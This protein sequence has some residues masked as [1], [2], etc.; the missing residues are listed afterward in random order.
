M[1]GN[2]SQRFFAKYYGE[3]Q[4]T[5]DE[6]RSQRFFAKYYEAPETP[7]PAVAEP[8]APSLAQARPAP[9]PIRTA[10]PTPEFATALGVRA[11]NASGSLVAPSI[12]TSELDTPAP[13]RAAPPPTSAPVPRRDPFAVRPDATAAVPR[14]P[15][16]PGES[17]GDAIAA[18]LRGTLTGITADLTL[19]TGR[20]LARTMQ[21]PAA[22]ETMRQRQ[23]EVAAAL[24]PDAPEGSRAARIF[25]GAR[26][27]TS[28]P[29]E[30]AKYIA[31]GG[32]VRS[33]AL[34]II[35][36]VG[37]DSD[38][39][40]A[41]MLAKASEV[42][43]AENAQRLFEAASKS[44]VG[45]GLVSAATNIPFE[46]PT[47]VRGFR[48][49]RA[50]AEQKRLSDLRSLLDEVPEQPRGRDVPP[51]APPVAPATDAGL[52]P[53]EVPAVDASK[54]PAP[55]TEAAQK[56]YDEIVARL[57]DSLDAAR[58]DGNDDDVK[59]IELLIRKL[60]ERSAGA[61][62]KTQVKAAW[63]AVGAELRAAERAEAVSTGKIFLNDHTD[64][65]GKE[66]DGQ[67]VRPAP[68]IPARLQP[69]R[70]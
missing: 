21:N 22:A 35:E 38:E 30:F 2:P 17:T 4:D 67:Q 47:L 56:A 46:I 60:D 48:A 31:M 33:A 6:E 36:A 23:E 66:F 40:E 20:R 24:R 64:L 19:G 57:D 18:Q 41:A 62:N 34:G 51:D 25:E 45:R 14:V 8:A 44:A 16:A 69:W 43:G 63:Q 37:G 65:L 3:P 70:V 55:R 58:D 28:L 68:R 54:P 42:L 29:L 32:P 53:V 7:A 11:G 50:A 26:L 10:P 13:Q 12:R 1:A 5:S 15:D 49:D 61:T 59:A 39:S 27:G 9:E 52:P